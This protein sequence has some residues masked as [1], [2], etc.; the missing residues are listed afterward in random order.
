MNCSVM[1]HVLMI[2]CFACTAG[3]AVPSTSMLRATSKV[4]ADLD[5]LIPRAGP[6][7]KGQ[8]QTHLHLT[9]SRSIAG[10]VGQCSQLEVMVPSSCKCAGEAASV[11]DGHTCTDARPRCSTT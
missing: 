4:H 8:S 9:P 10:E 7:T 2:V 11:H 1:C 3:V 5:A 6:H